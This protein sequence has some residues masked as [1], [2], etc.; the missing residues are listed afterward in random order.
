MMRWPISPRHPIRR[1]DPKANSSPADR[2]HAMDE[3]RAW[4]MGR[5]RATAEARMAITN[6]DHAAAE[7]PT[8]ATAPGP[9][10]SKDA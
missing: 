1:E 4:A 8:Q 7:A 6:R 9:S 3:D 2:D 10:P 5:D